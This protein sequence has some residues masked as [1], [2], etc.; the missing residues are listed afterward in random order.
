MP[1][2]GQRPHVLTLDGRQFFLVEQI[3]TGQKTMVWKAWMLDPGVRVGDGFQRAPDEL[4]WLLS[5]HPEYEDEQSV[6]EGFPGKWVALKVPRSG[7]ESDMRNEARQLRRLANKGQK[8]GARVIGVELA[9]A[10][11]PDLPALVLE[12]APGV[13]VNQVPP[14][15]EE[16]GIRLASQ[17]AQFVQTASVYRLILTDT[18]KPGSL[19]YDEDTRSLVLLDWNTMGTKP[20]DMRDVTLPILGQT[21]YRL[22]TGELIEFSSTGRAF[23]VASRQI[24]SDRVADQWDRLSFGT[25]Q[26]VTDLLLKRIPGAN[27][28]EIVTN[29]VHRVDTQQERVRTEPERLLSSARQATEPAGVLNH[30]DLA[31]LG[32][33]T[34]TEEDEKRYLEHT[35]LALR[36]VP[37]AA[38][39]VAWA[40]SNWARRTYP[41]DIVIRWIWLARRAAERD[42]GLWTELEPIFDQ[43]GQYDVV[44]ALVR[45]LAQESP[46][47]RL[48]AAE[49]EL[50]RNLPDWQECPTMEKVRAFEEDLSNLKDIWQGNDFSQQ[51]GDQWLLALEAI[52]DDLKDKATDIRDTR[53]QIEERLEASQ[54]PEMDHVDRLMDVEPSQVLDLLRQSIA[55]LEK[56]EVKKA[57]QLWSK[58]RQARVPDELLDRLTEEIGRQID[59][60]VQEARGGIRDDDAPFE[61]SLEA[62]QGVEE[63][64]DLPG[65]IEAN[66][67][68]KRDE[69][70][71]CI[72]VL[73]APDF[74]ST[75]DELVERVWEAL[76]QEVV[77]RVKERV[78]ALTESA[79]D[80]SEID[81]ER[82]STGEVE[83]TR[84]LAKRLAG[85]GR[86]EDV[87]VNSLGRLV[88]KIEEAHQSVDTHPSNALRIVD[89]TASYVV[90]LRVD[91][92]GRQRLKRWATTLIERLVEEELRQQAEQQLEE[93][94][95][96]LEPGG[97]R[98]IPAAVREAVVF[99][100][101]ADEFDPEDARASQYLEAVKDFRVGRAALIG[102]S[103]E[104]EMAQ[105][106]LERAASS[107]WQKLAHI[108]S[109]YL[110][111][112]RART[113]LQGLSTDGT[114]VRLLRSIQRCDEIEQQ[115][116]QLDPSVFIQWN[117]EAR[118]QERDQL[119]KQ[120]ENVRRK[121]WDRVKD[122]LEGWLQAVYD[123]ESAIQ[124]QEGVETWLAI[125]PNLSTNAAPLHSRIQALYHNALARDEIERAVSYLRDGREAQANR[126]ADQA[127][128]YLKAS[129]DVEGAVWPD[130]QPA[131]TV[132]VD[133]I[134][135]QR[136]QIWEQA[137][138][139][140]A[141]G[142]SIAA[143]L[144][145]V[146]RYREV[147]DRIEIDHRCGE[148]PDNA[149]KTLLEATEDVAERQ[150][151]A[152]ALAGMSLG[153]VWDELCNWENVAALVKRGRDREALSLKA[154]MRQPDP[155]SREPLDAAV[156]R[157]GEKY[158]ASLFKNLSSENW[159]ERA[160]DD[161]IVPEVSSDLEDLDAKRDND[162]DSGDPPPKSK[163]DFKKTF[164]ET[165][166][167]EWQ[168]IAGKIV[169]NRLRA[170]KRRRIAKPAFAAFIWLGIIVA[171][172][173]VPAVRQW[174]MTLAAQV[175]N[176]VAAELQPFLS[177][178]SPP[179]FGW[180]GEVEV[181]EP[182]LQAGGT[183]V[184]REV[185]IQNTGD[186]SGTF[187]LE[188]APANAPVRWLDSEGVVIDQ[189]RIDS[190][191]SQD[192]V[193]FTLVAERH[194]P[195]RREPSI[196]LNLMVD[197][198][199]TP[200]TMVPLEPVEERLE[201]S[202]D[203]GQGEWI[204]TRTKEVT[205]TF[206]I[207][208]E[209]EFQFACYD[210]QGDRV[211]QGDLLGGESFA[212]SLEGGEAGEWH[213]VVFPPREAELPTNR[214]PVGFDYEVAFDV[215]EPVYQVEMPD[216]PALVF[217]PD[218]NAPAVGFLYTF[219]NV[220]DF[221]DRFAVAVDHLAN[222]QTVTLHLSLVTGTTPESVV[223]ISS[224]INEVVTVYPI[225]QQGVLLPEASD[226]EVMRRYMTD[227]RGVLL[228]GAFTL[229]PCPNPGDDFCQML[230]MALVVENEEAIEG[231]ESP[232]RLVL[233]L[234]PREGHG[235]GQELIVEAS[236]VPAVELPDW[237]D[238]SGR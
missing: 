156:E 233:V 109:P 15:D 153:I 97:N 188:T 148:V 150:E 18:L 193:E 33:I 23:D 35:R 122:L 107:E 50:R 110:K 189:P 168:N 80:A 225:R 99:L 119:V 147:L 179:P 180:A 52:L 155:S 21:L 74:P 151:W 135:H 198:L 63:Q 152:A 160:D 123:G 59:R 181:E 56:D 146:D 78:Y 86:V 124:S 90:K 34:L 93:A 215:R 39:G 100:Q 95:K 126:S 214:S 133:E 206:D 88:E 120:A 176:R 16:Q 231:A 202:L 48:I 3:T 162:Y 47:A 154:L 141:R 9:C 230:R 7:F 25:R 30:Y 11:D 114:I 212:C 14:F 187:W 128:E 138:A 163:E 125:L 199:D 182:V 222:V 58:S 49:V 201:V 197:G 117:D 174:P 205:I 169:E 69:L 36:G 4:S 211:D 170:R 178:P 57:R 94:E 83:R 22:L 190:L 24:G 140:V 101:K 236:E 92:A 26:L 136:R 40:I 237:L 238:I 82:W 192:S 204:L 111:L 104:W 143:S 17:L 31:Q 60:R 28:G 96:R 41:Q 12:W 130:G 79:E 226:P 10:D 118:V 115:L 5:A 209:G 159:W 85:I 134:V 51:Y 207:S 213:A 70:D 217:D 75:S 235:Q 203:V 149:F 44:L 185:M 84:S 166:V 223:P 45:P 229:T 62:W 158:G 200:L 216:Q 234:F 175:K 218:P 68:L 194:P 46:A 129:G 55:C 116:G 113:A 37:L 132:A 172:A 127:Q 167:A 157:R 67:A 121:A 210:G 142:H 139:H 221:E 183:E 53:N 220:G 184:R 164:A 173:L 165:P 81:P 42:P 177:I 13:S 77:Q 8:G 65:L 32:G 144:Q 171:Y 91:D 224:N 98:E 54:L 208:I 228:P 227:Q 43:V 232:M 71:G 191:G 103:K 20:E 87:E 106:R 64:A 137:Y 6:P 73:F 66:D 145:E 108:A 186:L 195:S 102:E 19:F 89:Q 105:E 112:A 76:R 29:L 161:T 131:R 38:S 219:W 196:G 2:F 27:A 72:D 61:G 1:D